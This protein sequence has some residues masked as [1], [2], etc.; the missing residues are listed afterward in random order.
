LSAVRLLPFPVHHALDYIAGIFLIL[1][2]FIFGF[3][4]T[5]AFPVL[6]AVGVVF[7]LLGLLSGGPLGVVDIVPPPVHAALDYVAGL[8]LI[9]APF[10]F[11]FTDLD[12]ALFS[13]LFLGLAVFVES[14]LTSY[15]RRQRAEATAPTTPDTPPL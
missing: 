1:A 11:T 5:N 4:D 14:L 8:F 10:L 6:I 15:P 7:L 12:E 2:P 9:L 13:S 3:R